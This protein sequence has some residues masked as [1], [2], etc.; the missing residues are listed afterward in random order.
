MFELHYSVDLNELN[1]DDDDN[2]IDGGNNRIFF[3]FFFSFFF[4]G[5]FYLCI[6]AKSL[7]SVVSVFNTSLK[8]TVVVHIR[9]VHYLMSSMRFLLGFPRRLAAFILSPTII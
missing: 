1:D 5:V 7:Q 4:S 6:G 8:L 3:F 2:L 9:L